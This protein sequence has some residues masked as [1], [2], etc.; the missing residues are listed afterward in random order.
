MRLI[1]VWE[2]LSYSWTEIG[3]DES[4]CARMARDADITIADL[5]QIDRI[6]FRDV[7]AAFAVQS[8]LVFPLMLWM[9]MPDWGFD[10]VWLAEKMEHWYARPYWSHMLNPIRLVGY[11]VSILFALRYRSML[12]R[13]VLA[14]GV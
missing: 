10:D 9:L 12:R 13:V 1:A 5:P 7:C 2:I 3:I 6:F 8:F 11:P 14:T 4:M